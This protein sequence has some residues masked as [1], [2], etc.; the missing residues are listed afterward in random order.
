M[1]DALGRTTRL[2]P[3]LIGPYAM[4]GSPY[5]ADL[6]HSSR[7]GRAP[8]K[9]DLVDGGALPALPSAPVVRP[10]WAGP[11]G[12]SP[13]R[14]SRRR[15]LGRRAR[16]RGGEPLAAACTAGGE[17]LQGAGRVP[18]GHRGLLLQMPP[19]RTPCPPPSAAEPW[20]PARFIPEVRLGS[21]AA[22][23]ALRLH[24]ATPKAVILNYVHL[25]MHVPVPD[26][27]RRIR[28]RLGWV[29]SLLLSS[30]GPDRYLNRLSIRRYDE[31][32][33]EIGAVAVVS[34]DDYIYECD[35][36]HEAYQAGSLVRARKRAL[37]LLDMPGRPYS[38]I[39]LA[40]GMTEGEIRGSLKFLRKYGAR[41]CAFPCGD[42][43]KGGRKKA[44]IRSFTRQARELEMQSLLLGVACPDLLR[45]INPSWFSNSKAC[46]GP[47]Y[48]RTR[49]AAADL[50]LELLA[51]LPPEP[52]AL[53]RYTRCLDEN[54]ALAG[55]LRR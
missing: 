7:T 13:L 24:S 14:R 23:E 28:S 46:F 11:P 54:Y 50:G 5:C 47:A 40:A 51:P 55:G 36:P 19:P 49:T 42:Y 12:S 43:L 1:S 27:A 34:P 10:L 26:L 48:G 9:V 52:P 20:H 30:V 38:V 22:L 39:G 29:D 16:R 18:A 44:L 45:Q 35:D 41:C 25:P 3:S 33:R 4:R 6:P 31:V 32:A 2:L 37:D 15:G 17:V 53:D 8:L 21:K